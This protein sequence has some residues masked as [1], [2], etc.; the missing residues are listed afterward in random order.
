MRER[1]GEITQ[2]LARAF[3]GGTWHFRSLMARGDDAVGAG[4]TWLRELAFAVMQRWPSPPLE[5]AALLAEFIS[6]NHFF[7]TAW[8]SKQI[9]HFVAFHPT[10]GPR[11]WNV[12]RLDTI[13]DVSSWLQ[14]SDGE[15]SWL[16][17]RRGLERIASVE[18][19][20]H[21]RRRWIARADQLPR[22]LEAPKD[23]LKA[24][25]RRI[26]EEVLTPITPHDAAHG[27]VPCRSVVTH[28]SLHTGQEL[29]MRFDLQ[30]FF[31]N[32]ATWRALGVFKEA[33]YSA[34][35]ASVL[36]G[37]CTTR[38]PESVLR[39]APWAEG[40]SN[41]RFF[42]QRRLADWH[43]PQGAPTS[44]AL[45]NLAAFT[46]DV[47]LSGLAKRRGLQYSRYADD[48]VF[49]GPARS[50]GSLQ[51]QV[52]AVVRDEGFR[53]NEHKTRVMRAH[54]QQRV[55]GVVVNRKPNVS[56]AEFDSL[57]ALLHR[58]RVKGAL[59]QS[60][61]PLVDFLAE[62]QGRISWVTQLSAS[63]GAKLQRA[64]DAVKTG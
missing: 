28:A 53:L 36:L 52:A 5:N 32:V 29:V 46:L 2:A 62:L 17:D 9:P 24:I 31:T 1:R 23:R 61:G 13:G 60:T 51:Q 26:L 50:V 56:R 6:T 3:L 14:L 33:G 22:L 35:V 4:G 34:E 47:R 11:R 54:E 55:T 48:L 8:S 19:L 49:S 7:R 59:S 58:C 45:A 20:R 64:F 18:P 41:E 21:Y 39:E 16:A 10:M 43:L 37:F 63:R 42:L 12:P 40:L 27:F 25:Q 44:P 30:S 38:T 57:K 15:L